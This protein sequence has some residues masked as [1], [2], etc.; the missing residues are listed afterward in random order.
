MMA[1]TTTCV[2]VANAG[3]ADI[4]VYAL[5]RDAA[6]LRPLG[7]VKAA[8]PVQPLAVSPDRRRMYAA[9]RGEQP[10]IQCF[11]LGGAGGLPVPVAL[12]PAT[13]QLSYLAMDGSGRFLFGASYHEHHIVV[14]AVEGDGAVSERPVCRLEPGQNPHA[15]LADPD[16]R[17]VFVP[18]LGSNIV[19]Q[20][21]FDA[22]SGMLTSG[23][24]PALDHGGGPR[25]LCF[26]PDAGRLYV[27]TELSG[28][29]IAYAVSAETGWLMEMQSLPMFT[30]EDTPDPMWAADLNITPDGRFLYA[31]ERTGSTL[32]CIEV[33]AEG[34]LRVA[35]RYETETQ[36]RGFA[37]DA[38]GRFLIAAGEKSDHVSLYGIDGGS[39]DL[40]FKDRVAAGGRPNWVTVVEFTS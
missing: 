30:G 5:D 38:E 26:S 15:I 10:L 12:T 9:I 33:G 40:A 13:G 2:Y 32:T 4:S 25:H 28:E 23:E 24:P 17:R 34:G 1:E 22:A 21:G 29:V 11:D 37:I 31:S 3:T 19:A 6:K 36:P 7:A 16:N 18:A 27:I 20:Y 8:G 39:G 14:H 35:G